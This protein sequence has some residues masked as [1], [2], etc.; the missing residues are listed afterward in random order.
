M[1]RFALLALAVI[2]AFVLPA[3]TKAQEY[4]PLIQKETV[5]VF[6]L[7]FDKLDAEQL[8]SQ[9][10]T[11]G[12]SAV[13]YFVAD[14]EKAAQLKEAVPLAQVFVAQYFATFVQPLKDANVSN[15]YFVLDQS[16]DP[17]ETIYPY[18]AIATDR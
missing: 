5:A 8:S 7:N 1:K 15:M 6:R 12:N 16:D 10:I 13:D 14:T 2:S 18:I 9:A 3:T 4:A 11:L 17:D